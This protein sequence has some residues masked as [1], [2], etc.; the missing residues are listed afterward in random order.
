MKL[1]IKPSNTNAAPLLGV[2]IRHESVKHWFQEIQ[3][4]GLTLGEIECYPVPGL[5]ANNIIGCLVVTSNPISKDLIGQNEYCQRISEF[6]FIPEKA[7]LFP[8]VSEAELNALFHTNCSLFHPLVG[9]AELTDRLQY[10]TV[11]ALPETEQLNVFSPHP[12]VVPPKQ[13]YGFQVKAVEPDKV[14]QELE[15]KTFPKPEKLEDKPLSFVEKTKLGFYKALFGKKGKKG[16][17]SPTGKGIGGG[18]PVGAPQE[19]GFFSKLLSSL[20][21]DKGMNRMQEDMEAL[22]ER[23]QKMIDRLM[24][25]L[26]DNPDEALKYAIPLDETGSSRG[27]SMGSIDLSR[28]WSNFSL[29]GNSH[30]GSGSGSAL[31]GNQFQTLQE[32]YR[33][34][35]EN[36]RK[37][38]E[39]EKAAFIYIKLLKNRFKAAEVLEEGMLYEKAAAIFLHPEV[40][41]KERAAKCYEKGN[42]YNEA[43]QLFIELDKHEH[44]GDLYMK[45]GERKK[46]IER[47]EV[48]A[49]RYI[50]SNHYIKASAIYQDKI[51]SFEAAQKTLLRGW[52][53]KH[54]AVNCLKTYFKN[55]DETDTLRHE[56]HRIYQGD[57]DAQQ[58][59]YFLDVIKAQYTQQP[60]LAT[61]LREIAY[62]IVS[63]N[64]HTTPSVI[65]ELKL[66]NS[67][68][69]GFL[70]E[71]MRFLVQKKRRR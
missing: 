38:K 8:Q 68:N 26:R 19:P 41:A 23:N 45:I 12:G 13:L 32:Q 16:A 63:E 34:M 48:V 1:S 52:N 49:E 39:F 18:I 69:S 60:E 6:L 50:K 46:A 66:F 44:A 22:E 29:F 3:R 4:M 56:I 28:R 35:A 51:L 57:L 64:V 25:M 37:D 55:I 40:N 15:E 54:D 53:N 21:I 36:Y 43:I 24:K 17:A 61:E 2:L 59:L 47:Y 27:G 5:Q 62:E 14:L 33:Q 67:N 71:T 9:L 65:N 70:T 31:I 10:E 7:Q 58:Q 11:I 30:S 42:M 20:K